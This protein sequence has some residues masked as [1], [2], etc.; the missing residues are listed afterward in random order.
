MG[1]LGFMGD[2]IVLIHQQPTMQCN[3]SPTAKECT[4]SVIFREIRANSVART[5]LE[6]STNDVDVSQ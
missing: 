5:V 6:V 4:E 1:N 3:I 2:E